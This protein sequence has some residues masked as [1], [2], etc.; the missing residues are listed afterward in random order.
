L[1][2]LTKPYQPS[3]KALSGRPARFFFDEIDER[4]TAFLDRPIEGDWPYLWIDGSYVR[5]RQDGRIVSVAT[6]I[7]VGVNND[8]WRELLGLDIGAS[9]AEIFWT[10]FL[11]KLRR[12]G[13]R[14]SWWS[15]MPT[16][17]SRPWHRRF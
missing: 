7:A 16:K 10:E 2:I 1:G 11:R 13:L 8:G 5:V 15:R 14:V 4:V 9:E 3:L 6:I 12:R 17:A